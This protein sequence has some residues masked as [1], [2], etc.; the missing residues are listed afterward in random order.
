MNVIYK[1]ILVNCFETVGN[2]DLQIAITSKKFYV[3]DT[4]FCVL[5]T[6]STLQSARLYIK[7]Y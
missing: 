5:K 4:K 1:P 3:I 2:S 7:S 6:F